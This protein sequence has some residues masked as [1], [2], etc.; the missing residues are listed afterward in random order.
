MR[1]APSSSLCRLLLQYQLAFILAQG[2]S[3]KPA[4]LWCTVELGAKKC[5][6]IITP[7]LDNR[8]ACCAEWI[9]DSSLTKPLSTHLPPHQIHSATTT[10]KLGPAEIV[11][12]E[13]RHMILLF[14]LQVKQ[15]QCRDETWMGF[16]R[17]RSD[18]PVS[19]T[20]AL[21]CFSWNPTEP[22]LKCANLLRKSKLKWMEM[23]RE[24]EVKE[25]EKEKKK[26]NVNARQSLSDR[27]H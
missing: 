18:V 8:L 2:S 21:A 15:Q 10:T 27:L 23:E 22:P 19:C 16:N 1:W 6:K 11:C 24:R 17:A 5:L 13:S 4:S 26:P 7:L 14:S 25:R 12:R 9:A 20:E 3:L